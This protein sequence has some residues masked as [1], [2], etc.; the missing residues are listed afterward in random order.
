MTARYD[1]CLNVI[2][3]ILNVSALGQAVIRRPSPRRLGSVQ[4]SQCDLFGGKSGTGTGFSPSN[5]VLPVCVITQMLHAHLHHHAAFCHKDKRAK[6][7]NLPKAMFFFGNRGW[8]ELSR[9]GKGSTEYSG[10]KGI[11]QHTNKLKNL[12][13][14][15]VDY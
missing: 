10:V 4:V 11:I 9:S 13:N 8:K 3:I 6:R 1:L 12:T 5:S 14:F 7:G 2:H 15:L